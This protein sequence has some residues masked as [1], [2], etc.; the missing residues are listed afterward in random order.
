[1][2][3]AFFSTLLIAVLAAF[4]ASANP[5]G[6]NKIAGTLGFAKRGTGHAAPMAGYSFP[7]LPAGAVSTAMAG[8][9]GILIISCAYAGF[10]R[11]INSRTKNFGVGIKKQ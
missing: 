3:R 6:L 2:K 9:S 5:D 8:I 4:F 11:L 10:T 7:F 1:M